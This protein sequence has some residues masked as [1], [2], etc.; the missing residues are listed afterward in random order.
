MFLTPILTY[1][2]KIITDQPLPD[3]SKTVRFIDAHSSP[4]EQVY[5]WIW[6]YDNPDENFTGGKWPGK[7]MTLE[8]NVAGISHRFPAARSWYYTFNTGKDIPNLQMVF[9]NGQDGDNNKTQDLPFTESYTRS[10]V[11]S[12]IND[13]NNGDPYAISA[14]N[15]MITV[16]SMIS[17]DLTVANLQGCSRTYQIT[18]GITVINVTPG[19]YI[20]DNKKIKL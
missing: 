15:G 16:N 11:V 1:T 7:A 12:S 5:V 14:S 8:N 3:F 10:D 9:S 17:F 2:P 13:L 6:N 18:P 19:I 20:V 4:W